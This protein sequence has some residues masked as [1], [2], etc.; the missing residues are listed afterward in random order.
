MS[1]RALTRPILAAGLAAILAA[2][3]G[4][5]GT[6]GDPAAAVTGAMSAL[7]SKDL[8][9]LKTFACAAKQDEI[10]SQFDMAGGLEQL[11][12]GADAQ[13]ILG[14]VTIDTSG[15]TVGEPAVNGDSATVKLGGTMKVSVDA[16]KLKPIL[17]AAL[18]RQGMPADDA[19]LDAMLAMMGGAGATEVPMNETLELVRENG[20]WKLCE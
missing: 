1:V 13:A 10:A 3:S 8:E 12:P 14:A 7:Q 4:V 18:E 2:C 15:V 5:P 17:K 16:E 19:S 9:Q 20:A 11:V 6:G